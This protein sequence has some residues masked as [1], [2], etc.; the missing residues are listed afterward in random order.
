MS[1]WICNTCATEY[2][3][4][5]HAPKSCAICEDER[6]W[7]PPC[8]QQWT[9][10]DALTKTHKTFIQEIE[11]GLF[12]IGLTPN[13]AIGQIATFIPHPEG[14]ILWDGLPF[15][16]QAAVDFIQSKGGL[17]AITMSHP[18]LYGAL[19]SNAKLFGDVPVYLSSADKEWLAH[20]SDNVV[21]FDAPTLDLD[22]GVAV[23]VV[24]G[25]FDGSA[26]LHWS[27]AR[28]GKGVVLGGDTLYASSDR[29]YVSF[30]Y[31]TP[32]RVP[33]GLN[34]VRRIVSRTGKYDFDRLYCSWFDTFVPCDAKNAVLRSE[35]RW[36]R[37]F[38]AD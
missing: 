36:R 12:G 8:G 1:S 34:A 9:R 15:L 30:L 33:L 5:D 2:P 29:K 7:V 27:G 17:R 16:D 4:A 37:I 25:H 11:P 26:F 22:H 19:A 10:R 31:S 13:F 14:G 18:H 24:G 3:A 6:Q 23:E 21:F 32:N 38:L 35:E 28:D 20:P